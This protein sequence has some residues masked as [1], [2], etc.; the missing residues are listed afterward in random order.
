[1]MNRA[2]I[3]AAYVQLLPSMSNFFTSMTTQLRTG[4]PGVGSKS[5]S[6]FG[7]A[8][9]TGFKALG[10]VGLISGTLT[11]AFGVIAGSGIIKGGL[12]R[13]LN[14]ENAQQTLKALGYSLGQVQ[15]ISQKTLDAVTGTIYSLD[16]GVGVAASALAAGVS[17][18]GLT[19]Y[20]SLIADTATI[21]KA[22][23]GEI[24][25]IFNGVQA[26]GKAYSQDLNQLASRSI[27]I[28]QYL[29][30]SLGVTGEALQK[31]IEDGKISS[32]IFQRAIS[33]NIAGAALS[34]ADATEG[35]YLNLITAVDRFGEKATGPS[36]PIATKSL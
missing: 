16:Q 3:A 7:K 2:K 9:A 35:A 5:A 10:L 26:R 6:M 32:E 4:M 11:T 24:G 12:T 8:F 30:K 33:E 34:G 31:M 23:L 29:A 28:Y 17:S 22:E 14:I 21:A 25:L 27:P 18:E 36:L 13:A 1:M 19:N 15:V 20:I